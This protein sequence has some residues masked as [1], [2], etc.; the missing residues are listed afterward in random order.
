MVGM[1]PLGTDMARTERQALAATLVEVGP[2]APTLCDPWDTAD[3]AAHLVIRDRRP[4]LAAGIVV[5]PLA[6]RLEDAMRGY[7]ARPWAELVEDVRTGPPVWS[8]TRLAP[9]D[10]A[11]NLVE[12]VVHH[13]DVLRGDGTPGPRRV[14]SPEVRDALWTHLARLGRVYFRRAPVGVVLAT[15]GGQ[16]ATVKGT[17]E[18]GTVV[19]E[20]E[21]EELLLAAYGRRRVAQ[22]EETG[23]AEAVEALWAAPIGLA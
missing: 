9:V 12:F 11:V 2:D 14:L 10:E 21:P 18:L 20:G 4:D 13:E 8:P 1:F 19:L 17:T 15:P 7:A 16:R 23:G 6:G 22:I 5:P 3:L